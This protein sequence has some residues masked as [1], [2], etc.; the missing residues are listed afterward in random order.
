MKVSETLNKAADLIEERGWM[1]A[2]F[3]TDSATGPL[4]LEGGIL[5]AMGMTD[6][7]MDVEGC[8]AYV[9]IRRHLG[10]R[11]RNAVL[12]GVSDDRLWAWNDTVAKSAD[13]VIEVLRACALIESARERQDEAYAT[14]EQNIMVGA[15]S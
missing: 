5:A 10:T 7:V 3:G 13:E 12:P 4:C 6:W 1:K 9:A 2:A 8:P 11:C 15:S 14:Y